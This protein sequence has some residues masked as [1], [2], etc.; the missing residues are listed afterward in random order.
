MHRYT[1]TQVVHMMCCNNSEVSRLFNILVVREMIEG[2]SGINESKDMSG[3]NMSESTKTTAT[4]MSL[5]G[6]RRNGYENDNDASTWT[7]NMVC[8]E[9][10]DPSH[11]GPWGSK[12]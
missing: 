6:M 1:H 4:S 8:L 12:P 7:P 11:R 2:I 9:Q 10:E 3:T 5:N